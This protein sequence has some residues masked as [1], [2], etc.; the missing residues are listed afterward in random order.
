MET[1]IVTGASTGV[2]ACI[3]KRLLKMGYRVVGL[4]RSFDRGDLSHVE[5]RKIECDITN[6]GELSSVMNELQIKESGLNLLV[7]NAGIGRFGPHETIAISDLEKMIDVNLK[8][9]IILTKL[10]LQKLKQSRGRIINISSTSAL[11]PHGSGAAYSATK[12]ALLH[13]GDCLFEEVRKQ[14][15][16]VTTICPDMVAGTDFYKDASFET[17]EDSDSHILCDCIADTVQDVLSRRE[18]TVVSQ[19]VIKPQRVQ[20]EKKKK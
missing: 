3:A 12:A 4:A 8:A 5:F 7:N 15:V 17:G 6:S 20:I 1:A 13:F 18:G 9:P 16:K 2:G 14:G 19:I 11:K 10:A